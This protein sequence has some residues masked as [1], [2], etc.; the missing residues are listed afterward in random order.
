MEVETLREHQRRE[1]FQ[2]LRFHFADGESIEVRHPRL[3][4][5][6]TKMVQVGIPSPKHPELPHVFKTFKLVHPDDIVAVE[7]LA[8]ASTAS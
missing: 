1:P 8:E 6:A 2:P 5:I 7:V 4:L 3:L